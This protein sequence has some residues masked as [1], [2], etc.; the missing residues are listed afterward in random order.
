MRKVHHSK[1]L[2]NYAKAIVGTDFYGVMFAACCDF[3]KRARGSFLMR[4]QGVQEIY[5][6]GKAE[7]EGVLFQPKNDHLLSE[8]LPDSFPFGEAEKT[9]EPPRLAN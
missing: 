1:K 2:T 4:I 5:V 7:L 8:V 9:D 3:S 6:W